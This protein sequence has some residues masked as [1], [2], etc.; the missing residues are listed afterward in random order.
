M[1]HNS[2]NPLLIPPSASEKIAEIVLGLLP[3]VDTD[4]VELRVGRKFKMLHV[5]EHGRH[6]VNDLEVFNLS[7]RKARKLAY[8]WR[9]NRRGRPIAAWLVR[10]KLPAGVSVEGPAVY[11]IAP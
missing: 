8:R 4:G 5:I 9:G 6:F 2:F 1:N 10:S 3:R 7:R 11:R